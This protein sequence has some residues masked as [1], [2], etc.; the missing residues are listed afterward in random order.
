MK[1]I[2]I[3]FLASSALFAYPKFSGYGTDWFALRVVKNHLS[4]ESIRDEFSGKYGE[5]FFGFDGCSVS[6]AVKKK[7]PDV[8]WSSL[9]NKPLNGK[10]ANPLK[11]D[12][13]I[14]DISGLM[15][16]DYSVNRINNNLYGWFL[17]RTAI[18]KAGN[19]KWP[20][21]NKFYRLEYKWDGKKWLRTGGGNVVP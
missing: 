16:F 12:L 13:I 3:Y 11:R 21:L 7:F 9:K 15:E 4:W 14:V 5:V 6:D 20:T 1:I 8:K 10:L 19:T 18:L 2:F 17:V